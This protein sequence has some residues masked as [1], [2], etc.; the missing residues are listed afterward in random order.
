[1]K[2]LLCFLGL[3]SWTMT[4]KFMWWKCDWCGK[5]KYDHYL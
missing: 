5:K 4:K 1:M 3:H 2:K